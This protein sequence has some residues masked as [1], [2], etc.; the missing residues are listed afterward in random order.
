[1]PSYKS[2]TQQVLGDL[3]KKLKGI[4]KETVSKVVRT[5]AADLVTSNLTRIHNEGK[6]VDGSLIGEYKPSTKKIRQKAGKETEYKNFSFS[7]K[8]SK[9][10]NQDAVSDTEI[11]I[12]FTTDYAAE[13]SGHLETQ[14]GKQVWGVTEEDE[15]VAEEIMNEAIEKDLQ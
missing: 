6:A 3:T 13:I 1:M 14:V 10:F 15:K 9:E 11:G 8:L 2:N 4:Q 7:G 5:V 12:G